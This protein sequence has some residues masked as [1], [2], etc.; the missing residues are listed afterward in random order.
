MAWFGACCCANEADQEAKESTNYEHPALV[1]QYAAAGAHSDHDAI[2]S[3]DKSQ[4]PV[5]LSIARVGGLLTVTF[6]K[7]DL[8]GEQLG[9]PVTGARMSS[10]SSAKLAEA[11]KHLGQE[12]KALGVAFKPS[13][14]A[15]LKLTKLSKGLVEAYNK[16][17]DPEKRIY[18]G[19]KILSVNGCTKAEKMTELLSDS[20][21]C[22]LVVKQDPTLEVELVKLAGSKFGLQLAVTLN[23]SCLSVKELQAGIATD[24]NNSN[25]SWPLAVGQR[26][27][28]VNDIRFDAHAMVKE[29]TTASLLRLAVRD[30][31]PKTASA[32]GS[33]TAAGATAEE[34]FKPPL[35]PAAAGA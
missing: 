5:G 25:P 16:K 35:S 22:L 21:E 18:P 9:S 24:Y 6:A 26:I 1:E 28:A 31:E 33:P 3:A 8:V 15:A 2:L 27:V 13:G 4:V 30:P 10:A 32:P 11:T 23:G 14:P 20:D 29:I 12:D 7:A 34:E 17:V 19:D